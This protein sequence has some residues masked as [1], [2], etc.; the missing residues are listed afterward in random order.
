MSDAD[1]RRRQSTKSMERTTVRLPQERLDAI[2]G[3][4]AEGTYPNR[5]EAIRD[6]LRTLFSTAGIQWQPRRHEHHAT[7]TT[8]SVSN[9]H[10]NL[11]SDSY[12]AL[13]EPDAVRYLFQGNQVAIV[14]CSPEDPDAYPVYGDQG[15]TPHRTS[16]GWLSTALDRD[17]QP[18]GRFRLEQRGGLH[19]VDFSPEEG[20]A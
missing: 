4:V 8:I 11:I 3:L 18:N 14:P 1:A 10:L 6:A 5:S 19:V 17:D 13:G 7:S 16:A 15:N 12:E 2:D 9:Q 20:G